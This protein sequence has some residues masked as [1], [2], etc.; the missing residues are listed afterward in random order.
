MYTSNAQAPK[1]CTAPA[2]V[3]RNTPLLQ[4]MV[5]TTAAASAAATTQIVRGGIN[6]LTHSPAE[7]HST[8][9]TMTG[10]LVW[11]LTSWLRICR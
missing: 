9:S 6:D 11:L 2:T 8:P 10:R 5:A 4:A 3:T 7:M 1:A